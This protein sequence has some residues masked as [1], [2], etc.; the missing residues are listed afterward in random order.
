MPRIFSC[1]RSY[2]FSIGEKYKK[3]RCP[4][5]FHTPDSVHSPASTAHRSQQLPA[6]PFAERGAFGMSLIQCSSD[7]AYQKDGYCALEKAAEITN[8][9]KADA[10]LHFVPKKR[11]ADMGSHHGQASAS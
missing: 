8:A 10:C 1:A 5:R 2:K 4:T 7:C 9:V 6:R 3:G 11:K